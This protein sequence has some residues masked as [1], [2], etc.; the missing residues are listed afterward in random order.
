MKPRIESGANDS[1]SF[2]LSE[3][4]SAFLQIE[5]T[6]ND[7][8]TLSSF[9]SIACDSHSQGFRLELNNANFGPL[10]IVLTE[11]V[12]QKAFAYSYVIQA[13]PIKTCDA[14]ISIAFRF[15]S[16]EA[17][18]P[19]FM[20][21]G[22]LYGSNN[23]ANCKGQQVQFNYHGDI[24]WPKTSV[25]LTRADRSSHN[26]VVMVHK[27][28]VFG[29]RIDEAT[30]DELGNFVQYSGLGLDCSNKDH[31]DRIV[32]TLGYQHF[33]KKYHGNVSP[34]TTELAQFSAAHW[35]AGQNYQIGGQLYL[36]VLQS[37][38][39]QVGW[40]ARFGYEDC[41]VYFYQCMHQAPGKRGSYLDAVKDL[42]EALMASYNKCFHLFPVIH[43]SPGFS[44]DFGVSSWTGG[45]QV[46]Y[47]LLR[48][49]PYVQGAKQ[50]ALDF[51][52]DLVDHGLHQASGL[53]YEAKQA[54]QW[55]IMGWW[56]GKLS[57]YNPA[58]QAVE[59][60]F[61]AYVNGQA[62]C[63]LLKSYSFI[64]QEF[65]NDHAACDLARRCLTRVQTLLDRVIDK[66]RYD[67]AFGVYYDL[68]ANV[69]S[70]NG[71]QG[72]WF[73]AALAQLYAI[74]KDAR[75]QEAFEYSAEY[76]HTF[77][78]TLEPWG[79]PI[80]AN[81]AV[82]EEG[83]LAYITALACYHQSS[84][85]AHILDRLLHAI[86]YEFSWKFAYN[87]RHQNEPL[88]SLNWPSSGGSLTS[89][90]NIHLHQMG[91][92]I[93]EEI[94]YAYQLSQ[95]SYLHSRLLDTFEWGLRTHNS[96]DGEFGYGKKGWASEQFYHSDG[97][98]N[99]HEH[100][101]DGG[102]WPV[103][104]TWAASCVLLSSCHAL[105]LEKLGLGDCGL[106]R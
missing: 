95:D 96:F 64:M 22:V 33:P 69:L 94:F 79:T 4:S 66:R 39:E 55:Q 28:G 84:K 25:Y 21:P 3:S 31:F 15:R 56:K 36:N 42:A 62:S 18:I 16:S 92:L 83:N 13:H 65:K 52:N 75:Y 11:L 90:H 20:I 67:G 24:S 59:E 80:D 1:F 38:A 97:V 93:T 63:Y 44:E 102:I 23:L 58:G 43:G 81:D 82:D 37:E 54:D 50:I 104:L 76:Y 46:A 106:S 71:F 85:Q 51:I 8:A 91:N 78:Q 74:T 9:T 103:Y 87:T 40:P 57:Y 35:I 6:L 45:M 30:Y 27:D 73:L 26:A 70:Y 32:V 72:A 68:D 49:S 100:L 60:F 101:E 17:Q 88:K 86:H 99:T 89:S 41:L 61:S 34:A 10:V 105:K 53:F 14:I 19:F 77:F 7:G 29:V 98:Q 5:V 48:A 47:P 12:H 2:F